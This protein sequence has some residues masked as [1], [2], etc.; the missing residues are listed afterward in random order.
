MPLPMPNGEGSI[1]EFEF[2][3]RILVDVSRIRQKLL[4]LRLSFVGCCCQLGSKASKALGASKCYPTPQAALFFLLMMVW[5]GVV[6]KLNW[7]KNWT[8]QALRQF[9]TP[10]GHIVRYNV[11]RFLISGAVGCSCLWHIRWFIVFGNSFNSFDCLFYIR[12]I[13]S[14]NCYVFSVVFNML[15]YVI[16]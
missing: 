12:I 10:L 11:V 7:T 2:L 14:E 9:D 8:E 3:L 6:L 13:F 16:T 4:I 1:D 15:R 5:C